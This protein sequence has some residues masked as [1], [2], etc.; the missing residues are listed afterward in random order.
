[1]AM[2]WMAR[3]RYAGRM[4]AD[5]S[6]V[7]PRTEEDHNARLLYL[8]TAMVGVAS[9]GIVA[10]LPVFLARLG[11]D[12]TALSWLASAPALLAMLF[13]IPGAIIGERNPDQ[14]QVRVTTTRI[15]RGSYLLC[16]LAPWVAPAESLPLVLIAIW[17]LKTFPEAIMTPSW[18]AVMARAVSPRRRATCA[19]TDHLPAASNP[20]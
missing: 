10:F 19:A 17:T 20:E 16:A 15:V 14:V 2:L 6:I 5:S 4:L 3:L 18:T 8:N 9:G 13:L 11:A 1:M 7:R 12:S